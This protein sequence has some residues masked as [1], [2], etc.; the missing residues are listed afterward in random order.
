[1]A[2]AGT[3]DVGGGRHGRAGGDV[4]VGGRQAH[5][6]GG[7]QAHAG[8]GREQ[9]AAERKTRNETARGACGR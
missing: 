9:R 3:G 8:D 5:A 2:A 4:G 1:V 6:G 7:R